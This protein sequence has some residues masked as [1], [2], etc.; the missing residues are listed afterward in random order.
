VLRPVALCLVAVSVGLTAGCSPGTVAIAFH[1]KPGARYGYDVQV[2]IESVTRL[3]GQAPASRNDDVRLHADQRV[4]EAGPNGVQ[5]QVQLAAP[6]GSKTTF[7]VRFDRAAQPAEVQQTEGLPSRVLG[8][9]GLS[10]VFPAAAGAPPRRSLRPGTQWPIDQAV[11][12]GGAAPSQLKGSGRLVS[13]GVVSGRRVATVRTTYRLPV[14][15]VTSDSSGEVTLDGTE[16][17]EITTTRALADGAVETATAHTT[18]A[19]RVEVRPPAPGT[20]SPV[21]GRLSVEVRST[22]RRVSASRS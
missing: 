20:A 22:T 12:F 7:V 1:P 9:L 14:R 8:G 10:E 16:S 11:T 3:D 17:S 15:T 5:V 13:L 4:L 19:F 6:D 18:G 2:H 21:T